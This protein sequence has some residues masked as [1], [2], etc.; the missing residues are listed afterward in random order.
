MTVLSIAGNALRR[1]F[2]DRSNY[3]FVFVLPLAIVILIGAQFGGGFA[4][5]IGVVVG[6]DDPLAATVVEALASVT[7]YDTEAYEDADALATAVSRGFVDA[8]V[9]LPPG[10]T[11]AIASG[12]TPEIGFVSRPDSAGPAIRAAIDG[13]VTEALGPATAAATVADLQGMGFAAATE[14]VDGVAPL[15]GSVEVRTTTSGEALFGTSIGQFDVGASTQLVLFMFLTALTGSAALIQSRQLG[16]TTRMLSTPASARVII[17]GEGLG[18]LGV[19]VFQGVYIALVTLFAF[20]VDW[21]DVPG[22]IAILIAFGL[23]GAGAAM[24]FGSIFKNDQQAG[25]VS[26]VVG[27]GLAA[28]GGSMVPLEI[29]SPTMQTVAKFTPHAWANEAFAELVRRDGT[30]ADILTE[31]GVLLA[32][33]VVLVL[34][35]SW[36]LRRVITRP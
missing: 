16:V 19:A 14:L 31:L 26:V 11:D 21:G 10:L 9:V 7:D 20:R 27:L 23:V 6:D 35:A 18:R 4:P 1:F 3:F 25:G 28:I 32:I 17:A 30:I 29:F 24:L 2:R 13:V 33:G 12:T 5:T 34:L 22:T 8:G 36:R 15:V